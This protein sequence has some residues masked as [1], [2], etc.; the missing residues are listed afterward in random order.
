MSGTFLASYGGHA[1]G[2]KILLKD[3]EEKGAELFDYLG[4]KSLDEARAMPAE[5]LNRRYIEWNANRPAP[6]G[7]PLHLVFETAVDG[8]FC[9]GGATELMRSGRYMWP[10][11]VCFVA[12][13]GLQNLLSVTK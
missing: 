9:P 4:F 12:T 6:D 11:R 7:A 5:E 8:N 13:V 2:G 3:A 10:G 1:P